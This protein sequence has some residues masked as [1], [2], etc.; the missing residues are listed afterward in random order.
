MSDDILNV[1]GVKTSHYIIGGVALVTALSWNE[2]IKKIISTCI[3]TSNQIIASVIYSVIITFILVLLIIFLPN[4]ESELPPPT[5][6]K[7][8]EIREKGHHPI[9]QYN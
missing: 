1:L 6:E 9:K 7:L 4:T 3:P 5:K 8:R 2:T